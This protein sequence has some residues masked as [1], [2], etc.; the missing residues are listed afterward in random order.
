MTDCL[1]RIRSTMRSPK[2]VGTVDRRKST[3]RPAIFMRTR[4]SCGNRFS[5][6]LRLP[7]ILMR[8]AMDAWNRLGATHD[9][10]EHAV[11]AEAHDD[12]ERS[13]GSMWMSDARSLMACA[14]TE[15]TSRMIGASSPSSRM[16]LS[17]EVPG[18]RRRSPRSTPRRGHRRPDR[19]AARRSKIV[20]M[21]ASASRFGRDDAAR[22]RRTKSAR[23]SSMPRRLERVADRHAQQVTV[24]R[25]LERQNAMLAPTAASGWRRASGR[26]CRRPASHEPA[27][28][29]L[30][31]RLGQTSCSLTACIVRRI[32]ARPPTTIGLDLER[33]LRSVSDD[34]APWRRG[35]RP[36]SAR[37]APRSD[38]PRLPRRTGHAIGSRCLDRCLFG[39]DAAPFVWGAALLGRHPAG[40][41]S[42]RSG[43]T[44]CRGSRRSD[45]SMSVPRRGRSRSSRSDCAPCSTCM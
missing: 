27:A 10:L 24:G 6:M 22:S 37:R 39:L 16:S 2:L 31:Q 8:D 40:A 3:S 30:G 1:S 15:F 25:C 19:R 35:R 21:A 14:R 7:M 42:L 43:R 45:R 13:N 17:V 28:V 9:L 12:V 41:T 32:S 33:V 5:A 36:Q 26:P 18:L 29:E 11:L 44:R 23:R 34:N 4:P 20:W 38:L